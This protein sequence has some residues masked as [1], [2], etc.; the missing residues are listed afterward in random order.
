[1]TGEDGLLLYVYRGL[2]FKVAEGVQVPKAGSLHF[3]RHLEFHPGEGVLELG[4]GVGVAAVL[5]AK[6]GCQVVATDIV[7]QAVRCARENA[8]LNGVGER[9]EVLLGDCYD[10]VRGKSFDLICSNP[11]QMPTPAG[12]DRDD[13]VAAADNGGVDGWE[14]LDRVIQGAR[15]HLN[16]GGR[17]VFTI[18]AFLGQK[19][20]C[21]KLEA[22]GLKPSIIAG[23]VQV[24]PRIG[25]ERLDHI[26]SLDREGVLPKTGLPKTVERLVIQGDNAS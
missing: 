2:L 11:P 12:R 18:F 17:L 25:Y 26:R 14:V 20:A 24:F 3:C 6:A 4:T 7:P 1:M 5:A 19:A 23:E 15:A 9:V 10:A 22:V 21:S 13:S 8:L 16:P